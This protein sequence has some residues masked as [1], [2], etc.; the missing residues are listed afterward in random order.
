MNH[1]S[2]FS[3][4]GGFD[5]A[6]EWCGWENV[7]QC[8][9]DEFCQKV[10]MHHFPEATLYGDIRTIKGKDWKGKID[11]LTGGFPCQPF[12]LAG[13][14]RGEDDN[15]FLWPEMCRVIR[16]IEPTFVVAENVSGLLS[17]KNG[18][19]LEQV[20]ADLEAAGYETAPPLQIPACAIGACHRRDRIW[21]VAYSKSNN[22]LRISRELQKKNEQ[23]RKSGQGQGDAKP[24][25]SNSRETHSY[26]REK[27]IERRMYQAIPQFRGIQRIEDGGIY[28]DIEGRPDLST[29][30][31]CRS[32]HGIPNGM[33]RVASCGNAIVPQIAYMI[34]QSIILS[35]Q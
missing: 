16:E 28:A 10:L 17:I 29:P 23:V 30:V 26:N 35:Q 15:R 32:Y 1:A 11:I 4:I 6:A 25:G 12:S 27:R 8:D 21:I 7:L 13:R 24:D 9:N 14:R 34:F 5:L 31:L 18:M 19:V 22:H 20:Y 3:G 33:D 2:L